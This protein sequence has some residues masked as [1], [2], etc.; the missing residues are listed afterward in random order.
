MGSKDGLDDTHA[1]EQIVLRDDEGGRKADDI[2]MGGLGEKTCLLL[3]PVAMP[4]GTSNVSDRCTGG[5]K[6]HERT[7]AAIER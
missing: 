5:H 2:V 1:L 7:Y 4:T 3:G 6:R